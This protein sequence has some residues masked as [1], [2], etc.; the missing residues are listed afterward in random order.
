MQPRNWQDL[1]II[2]DWE[3]KEPANINMDSLELVLE[4]AKQVIDHIDKGLKGGVGIFEGMSYRLEVGP[5]GAPNFVLN[6]Y[7]DLTEDLTVLSCNEVVANIKKEQGKDW[8]NDVADGFSFRYLES[9]GEIKDSDFKKIPYVIN[10]IPDQAELLILS[11]SVFMMAKELQEAIKTLAET[12]GDVTDAATPVVGAG[13]GLGAVAVTAWDIGNIILVAIK[14]IANI[15]YV[16]AII[17]AIVKLIDQVIQQ[18]LPKK[19][20]H[21][22]MTI[23][24]LFQKGCEH[25]GLTLKSSLLD[26]IPN[27][28]IIPSKDHKGG[29]APT[30]APSSWKETG[31]PGANDGVDTF[32]DLI[33]V[34]KSVFNADCRINNGVFEFERADYWANNSSYK[35]PSTFIDQ[36]K[37][38]NPNGYNTAELVANYNINY[39]YDV[40]DQNTL[41]NLNGFAFQA[42]TK[43][44]T[45]RNASLS[46]LKG[47]TE[48]SLPFSMATRKN[49][50]T[51]IEEAIKGLL[52]AVDFLINTF[53]GGKSYAGRINS[54]VGAMHLSSHFLS[55]PKMVELSGSS[56]AV[57]QRNVLSAA[58]LW[59]NYHY[60]NS[61][62]EIGG[63]HGQRVTYSQHKIPFCLQNFVSLEG[64]NFATLDTGEQAEVKRLVWNVES[65]TAIIDYE[66][67]RKYTDNLKIELL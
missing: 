12:G 15:A 49:E 38:Q 41:D 14:A 65:D 66:V 2:M 58:N 23:K 16:V 21:L 44:K 18:L 20:Y 40:Q 25:L 67:K 46:N 8:L 53:G 64:N 62:A 56:L 17:I 34:F 7:L 43:P 3:G 4:D 51:T 45:S 19:R 55:I 63:E 52:K 22:G 24:S 50:L 61:F 39:R 11:I 29:K 57:N 60:I 5:V 30:D 47:L 36:S 1:E 6:S 42:I 31:V 9:I 26:A 33:R 48:I 10:Y 13:V 28:V 54:R 59:N 35:I 32:G 37:L 27:R